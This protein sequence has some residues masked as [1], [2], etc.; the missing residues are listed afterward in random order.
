M[1]H[2]SE[3]EGLGDRHGPVPEAR[4]GGE[5]L[6][7]DPAL[8]ELAQRQ[9]RLERGHPAARDQ[10]RVLVVLHVTILRE[11]APPGIGEM[12]CFRPGF[13]GS[14]RGVRPGEGGGAD[15]AIRRPSTEATALRRPQPLRALRALG[16]RHMSSHTRGGPARSVHRYAEKLSATSGQRRFAFH[17]VPQ[18]PACG[19]GKIGTSRRRSDGVDRDLGRQL[20]A[21]VHRL[22]LEPR[23]R[24]EVHVGRHERDERQRDRIDEPGDEVEERE[25][26]VRDEDEERAEE[27]ARRQRDQRAEADEGGDPN[28]AAADEPGAASERAAGPRGPRARRRERAGTSGRR[29]RSPPGSGRRWS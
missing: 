4:L 12:A 19:W 16:G 13:Y 14:V 8:A 2:L 10:H 22:E 5:Q 26:R 23:P 3:P 7:A 11:R 24:V 20:V 21:R 15:V 27:R 28:P 29:A 25:R 18:A 9:R 1:P 17:T 6:D